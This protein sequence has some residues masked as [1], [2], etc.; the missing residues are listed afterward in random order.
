MTLS[1]GSSGSARGAVVHRKSHV[2]YAVS[3][4]RRNFKFAHPFELLSLL[5]T[6]NTEIR[7]YKN[8]GYTQYIASTTPHENAYTQHLQPTATPNT[9]T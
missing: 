7:T 5:L 6:K 1:N 3:A 2:I 8:A 9:H 4:L